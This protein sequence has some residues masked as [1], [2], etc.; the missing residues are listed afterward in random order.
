MLDAVN[1]RSET[2]GSSVLLLDTN[3]HNLILMVSRVGGKK[4]SVFFLDL[5]IHALNC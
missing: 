5:Q 3:R 4:K 2:L 1:Q